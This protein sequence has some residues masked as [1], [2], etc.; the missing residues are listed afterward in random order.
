M[1]RASFVLLAVTALGG[2]AGESAM[3]ANTKTAPKPS[4]EGGPWVVENING[5]GI[6]D[7]AR[8]DLTF[9]G[10]DAGTSVVYGKSGCNRYRGAWK[11]D[12][13]TVKFGPLAGTMMACAPALMDLE[14]KFLKTMEVVTTVSFDASGAALLKA[15]DGR[16]I[17]MRRESK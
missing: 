5:G 11:Q 6:I 16:A 4:L 8:V 2:C 13:S 10:G 17:T 3:T 1:H 12:G 9:E 7:D 15:P 14:Q